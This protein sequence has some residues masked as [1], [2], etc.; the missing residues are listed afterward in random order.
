MNPSMQ[1]KDPREN[2]HQNMENIQAFKESFSGFIQKFNINMQIIT[3]DKNKRKMLDKMFNISPMTGK[4]RIEV[5]GWWVT[6]TGERKA[7]PMLEAYRQLKEIANNHQFEIVPT[8][9]GMGED[10][11]AFDVNPLSSSAEEPN[12]ALNGLEAMYGSGGGSHG[13]ESKAADVNN[14]HAFIK[15]SRNSIVNSLIKQGFGG[16][17]AS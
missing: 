4:G 1:K 3:R 12:A 14:K 16:K 13:G 11:Y 6:P 8:D 15:E 5:P 9:M 10:V 17:N 7:M 2:I